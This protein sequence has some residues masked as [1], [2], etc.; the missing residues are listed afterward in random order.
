MKKHSGLL[1]LLLAGLA[2]TGADAADNCA[3]SGNLQLICGPEA[4]EDL[5][6]VGRS[7]W[8]IGSGMAEGDKGGHL[9]LIDTRA[10]RWENLYPAGGPA[11]AHDAKRFPGCATE[12]DPKKFSAHGI[13]LRDAGAGRHELLVVNH[14][15]REAIEYFAVTQPGGKPVVQWLGCVPLP[16][17]V[18]ANSVAA[19]PDGGFVTSLFNRPSQGGIDAVFEAKV[20]GGILRWSPGGKVTEIPGTDVSGANGIAVSHDG[21]VI[22]LAAWGTRELVR[23]E[24]NA[25]KLSKKTVKLGFAGDNLRWSEDGRSLLIGG[26]KFVP[27]KGGPASLD[28]W[29]VVRVD[30]DTLAVKMLRD[31]GPAET[32]QG[33]TVGVEVG[34]EI[35]VGQFRG[36]QVGFF[37]KP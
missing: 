33:I 32:M 29:S 6:R 10:R 7:H 11:G 15:G 4:V 17:D 1:V 35:W 25:G 14:G 2:A 18:S 27:R 3:A 24:W 13:E 21:R 30:P 22:H 20:T 19:M 37:P 5:V 28:G 31:A 9:R 26:Q 34:N 23:F 16:A 36:N 12:P 8:L